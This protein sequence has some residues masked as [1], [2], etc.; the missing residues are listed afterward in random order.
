MLFNIVLANLGDL[1]FISTRMGPAIN[2]FKKTLSLCGH[3]VVISHTAVRSDSVNLFFEHF[4]S[5]N[6]AD[7]FKKL[8]GGGIRVGIITTEVMINNS[9]PYQTH[10]INY[11]ISQQHNIDTVQQ[12]LNGFNLALQEVDF[13]WSMS[14]RTSKEYNDKIKIHKFFPTGCI[15]ILKPEIRRSV[16]DIDVLFFGKKTPHRVS[17]LK[18]LQENEVKVLAIGAG[19]DSG[20]MPDIFL[21]SLIDRSK[22]CLNLTLHARDDSSSDIDPRFASSLRITDILSRG[23]LVVSESIPEDNSYANYMI[24]DELHILPVVCK[25][26][27]DSGSWVELATENSKNFEKQMN[28]VDICKPI[29]DQTLLDL[30]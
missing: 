24:S 27:I 5:T 29:I 26:I 2:Y 8:R 28:V 20:Y 14:Q 23:A 17:V 10:G 12:R 4:L 11:G 9:I 1:S 21:E 18:T 3:D 16:K 22:I 7:D 15:E 6:W 30:V 19:W 25:N 13:L